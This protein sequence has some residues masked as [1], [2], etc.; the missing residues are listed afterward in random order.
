MMQTEPERQFR[1]R[2]HL[3]SQQT[4]QTLHPLVYFPFALPPEIL[5]AP[6]ARRKGRIRPDGA[7]QRALVKR[8]TG[9][10]THIVRPAG[11]KQAVFGRLVEDVV[12]RLHG[13]YLSRFHKG[14]RPVRFVLADGNPEI[15]DLAL[16]LESLKGGIPF[17]LT[18]PL[19]IPHMQL[20]Q[21]DTIHPQVPQRLLH[22]RVDIV[23]GVY[24]PQ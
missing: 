20:D 16:L 17:I 7:G 10:D 22:T 3:A 19:R 13:V 1:K 21:V 11:G 6:V 15:G 23:S 9:K 12:D 4:R 14:N 18:G 24:F 5:V 8:D 2:F